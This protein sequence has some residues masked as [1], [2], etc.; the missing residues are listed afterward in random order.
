MFSRLIRSMFVDVTETFFHLFKPIM[1]RIHLKTLNFRKEIQSIEVET[2]VS[3][4]R[5][6]VVTAGQ[7]L[8]GT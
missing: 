2:K 6:V 7:I 4:N 3:R 5:R 1:M 8:V